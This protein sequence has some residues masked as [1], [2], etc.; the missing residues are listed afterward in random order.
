[1][2]KILHSRPVCFLLAL[3]LL[4]QNL[5]IPVH[6]NGDGTMFCTYCQEARTKD[7]IEYIQPVAGAGCMDKGMSE[8]WKCL[9]CKKNI[10]E[11]QPTD[12]RGHTV[13]N[14]AEVPATCTSTGTEAG[15]KCSVCGE[16]L[17]GLI[18]IPA[19][20]HSLFTRKAQAATCTEAG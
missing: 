2:K 6:A 18:E 12:P 9:V 15:T 5:A 20:G 7:Q 16:V 17:S 19:K 10:V 3:M 1:M 11:P 8:G 14:V 13:Q 4:M